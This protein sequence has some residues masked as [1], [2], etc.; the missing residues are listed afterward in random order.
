MLENTNMA[1][2]S[3]KPPPRQRDTTTNKQKQ[4][5]TT[6]CNNTF[7]FW[8]RSKVSHSYS[9]G[10]EVI[11]RLHTKHWIWRTEIQVTF[12]LLCSS[13]DGPHSRQHPCLDSYFLLCVFSSSWAL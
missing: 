8:S 7:L 1:L 12:S 5:Q 11:W 3:N 9:R 13:L 10:A 2:H 6:I 4:Y